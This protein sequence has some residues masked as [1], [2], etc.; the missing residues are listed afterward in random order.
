MPVRTHGAEETHALGVALG[1][2]ARPGDVLWLHG[3]LGA[4]KTAL[5]AG[6]AAGL[7]GGDP[8]S[9]PSFAL[10]HEYRRGRL[11][12]FHIDLYRL[13]SP[14]ALDLGLEDYLEDEGVTVI[15]WGERLPERF[16]PDGLAI[17]I[18]FVED[19]A[20]DRDLTLRPRG[21]AGREWLER[22]NRARNRPDP[23]DLSDVSDS[24]DTSDEYEY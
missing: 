6:M 16:F 13:D 22:Y 4:G 15:E 23:S 2:S 9:S 5:T 10:I 7:Q 20:D 3:E 12:L 1:L 14:A 17:T 19:A 18:T 8:V 24:S 21:P 11:P